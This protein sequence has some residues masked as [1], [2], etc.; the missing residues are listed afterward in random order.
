MRKTS[1][2]PGRSSRAASG[3]HFVGV[4]PER[5][6]VLREREVE[7]RVRQRH[8]LARRLDER[9]LD[10][11]LAPACA[12]PSRAAPASGRRR[13]AARRAS[14]ATPRST[15]CRSR[16]RRRRARSRR[17]GRRPRTRGS[18]R[19]PRRSRPTP[20]ARC[21]AGSVNSAFC[22]VHCA[23][24]A[25]I[26][27]LS[28]RLAAPPRSPRSATAAPTRPARRRSSS[29]VAALAAAWTSIRSLDDEAVRAQER[30]SS[31]RA[32]RWNSIAV[33][34]R[35]SRTG[36]CRST[37]AAAARV[38]RVLVVGRCRGARAATCA[39]NDEPAAGPQQPRGLRDPRATGRPR[40]SAP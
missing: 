32:A 5:G 22:F 10:P 21:A 36:A 37:A 23:M 11:G 27:S 15:R 13:P 18:R 24:F 31:R 29:C 16:A 38:D 8:G 2:P 1:R 12:A 25:V 34:A 40:S 4:G 17:R 28:S 19:R 30:G 26:E 6:A 7:R 3:I 20:S 14:R 35:A 39:R 33:V 9:E